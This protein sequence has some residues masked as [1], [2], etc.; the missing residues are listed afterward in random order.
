MSAHGVAVG[1]D[2]LGGHQPART[3]GTGVAAD[4]QADAQPVEG[5][6]AGDEAGQAPRL[7]QRQGVHRVDDQRLD[8]ALAGLT[9]PR[10]VVQ[11]GV[12]KAF[13]FAAAGARGH[14]GVRCQPITGQTLPGLA[15]VRVGGVVG[16]EAGEKIPAGA[17]MPE[18]QA[19]L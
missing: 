5:R 17:V 10:A 14:Q 18:G 3:G 4:K 19:D 7:I 6:Y 16:L 2:A 13:G 1:D 11:N 15:L 8:A 12:G 9:R